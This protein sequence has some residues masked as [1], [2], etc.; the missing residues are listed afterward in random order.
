VTSDLIHVVWI[1]KQNDNILGASNRLCNYLNLSGSQVF[2]AFSSK[3]SL[4]CMLNILHF[5]TR[6]KRVEGNSKEESLDTKLYF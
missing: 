3:T 5:R 2:L 1:T 4:Y 6:F